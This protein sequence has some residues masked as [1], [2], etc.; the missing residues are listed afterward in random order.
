MADCFSLPNAAELVDL[1]RR[2][3]EHYISEEC[4]VSLFCNCLCEHGDCIVV[5]A[6][7]AIEKMAKMTDANRRNANA[8]A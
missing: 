1:L 8:Y 4:G 2:F 5:Q 6:A 7:D 3:E